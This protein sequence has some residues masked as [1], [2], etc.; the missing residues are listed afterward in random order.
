MKTLLLLLGSMLCCAACTF[1]QSTDAIAGRWRMT[2]GGAE[3][4]ISP[5]ATSAGVFTI[6]LTDT[7]DMSLLPGT[8]IGE[9]RTTATPGRYVATMAA[10]PNR[11]KGK[12]R[13]LVITVKP[14][15]SLSFEPYRT[16][17]SISLWRWLPY[18]FRV[19]V[20]RPGHQPSDIEGAVRID[21]PDQTRHRVL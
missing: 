8:I 9:A 17:R 4:S 21:R 18:M 14:N 3:F 15:G 19:T 12:K 10:N 13:N 2:G 7:D 5:S 6:T 11:P 20:T 16:G 1:A